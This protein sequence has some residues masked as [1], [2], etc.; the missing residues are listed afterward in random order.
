MAAEVAA[1]EVKEGNMKITA[2]S[3][4]AYNFPRRRVSFTGTPAS[5]STPRS[6]RRQRSISQ[7]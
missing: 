3:P 5:S 7:S 4:G 6:P 2:I 1:K